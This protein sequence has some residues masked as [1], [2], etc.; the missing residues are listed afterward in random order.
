[1]GEKSFVCTN[2]SFFRI[3]LLLIVT[4]NVDF[5]RYVMMSNYESTCNKNITKFEMTNESAILIV[6]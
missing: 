1:M 5:C 4:E 3:D 2:K 6:F